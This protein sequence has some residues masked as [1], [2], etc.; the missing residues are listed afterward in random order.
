MSKGN[1]MI[2]D[3]TERNGYDTAGEGGGDLKDVGGELLTAHKR[4]FAE[5]R[6][7]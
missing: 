7:S 1:R 2:L 3:L 4:C 5:L 6:R